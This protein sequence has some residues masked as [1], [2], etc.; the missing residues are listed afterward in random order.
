LDD[1]EPCGGPADCAGKFCDQ[2]VCTHLPT[3]LKK[4]DRWNP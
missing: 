1:G 4:S 2:G 3:K